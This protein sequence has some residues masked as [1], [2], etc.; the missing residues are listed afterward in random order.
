[1]QNLDK[2]TVQ[3]ETVRATN[4]IHETHHLNAEH[5]AVTPAP[6]VDI[7]EYKTGITGGNQERS[8]KTGL[9]LDI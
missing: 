9:G 3:P 1:M 2:E 6:E 7:S 4:R 5:H 8:K